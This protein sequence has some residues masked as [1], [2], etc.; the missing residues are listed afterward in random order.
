MAAGVR[1]VGVRDVG[2]RDVGIRDEGIR[3]GVRFAWEGGW[4]VFCKNKSLFYQSLPP[5][6]PNHFLPSSLITSSLP[7]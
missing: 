5:F 3:D 1:D 6:L 4:M 2:V 7:P